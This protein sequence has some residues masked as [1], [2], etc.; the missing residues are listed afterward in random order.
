[1]SNF[2]PQEIEE[3]LQE[4]FDVVGARQ[5][6]GARYVPIFGRAGEATV[7]WDGLAPYEPLTVV[8]HEGISYVSRR[9]V[10]AGIQIANTD[11]WV[12]TYRFNAQV[13]QYRQEVLGF[14]GQIDEIREDFVP[15]PA[16]LELPKYGTL[17]Q[18]LTTLAN[19]ATKWEDP[20]VP[21][22][23]QAE[24]VIAA[25]LDEHP[26]ATTTVQDYS[27]T[28]V[29]I[30]DNQITDA[31]LAQNGN[32]LSR[33]STMGDTIQ[34]I[35][36]NYLDVDYLTPTGTDAYIPITNNVVDISN[37][38]EAP[39]YDYYI[40]PCKKDD[41]FILNGEGAV[42]ARFWIMAAANNQVL[43]VA[44]PNAGGNNIVLTIPANVAYLVINERTD[45][46]QLYGRSVDDRISEGDATN[47]A[48][49]E[50]MIDALSYSDD[51]VLLT[52]TGT[53]AYIPNSGSTVDVNSPQAATG[54][55]YY[56][57]DC[58]YM[59]EFVINGRGS[60]S[61]R[62]WSFIDADG[63]VL[64]VAGGDVTAD[65]LMI[66]APFTA[67][68]LVI[69]NRTEDMC[70]KVVQRTDAI[71][72]YTLDSSLRTTE[73]GTGVRLGS[74]LGANSWSTQTNR[75][76]LT[77][78]YPVKKGDI[79]RLNKGACAMNVW[80]MRGDGTTILESGWIRRDFTTN[81][82]LRAMDYVIKN[83][84]YMCANFVVYESNT[85]NASQVADITSRLSQYYGVITII[86]GVNKD[87]MFNAFLPPTKINRKPISI[88]DDMPIKQDGCFIGDNLWMFTDGTSTGVI[89]IYD[90][91]S[92]TTTT[93]THSLGHA[94]CVTYSPV[95][96][97][98]CLYGSNGDD[99][100]TIV[101]YQ[102]PE[103]ASDLQLTDAS[104]VV[105]PLY[106]NNSH[107]NV[108]ASVC[109]GEDEQTVY[110]IDGPEFD[111]SDLTGD[112]QTSVRRWPMSI[113]KIR[114]GMGTNDLSSGGFGTYTAV[115]DDEYNG[116]G[117]IVATYT[118]R[119]DNGI[120][121]DS[122]Y[123]WFVPQGVDFDGYIYLGYG[124]KNNTV[125]KILLDDDTLTYRA[126]DN[127]RYTRRNASYQ[128]QPFEPELVALH[129]SRVYYG[130]SQSTDTIFIVYER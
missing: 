40:V 41:V 129:G 127:Y 48:M 45:A 80:E 58:S 81:T 22:D 55:R 47:R 34:A 83:D 101:L 28:N 92:G 38:I 113:Y 27:I 60:I 46:K 126:I 44:E 99:K 66:I 8:M 75:L 32:V 105:I 33:V 50:Q 23:A 123:E 3:F 16:E 17:G 5:Y 19:G 112:W 13:E 20:V 102:N 43:S 114:L 121:Q 93:K 94:N 54:W 120:L 115:G 4:F 11:Y 53:D 12:Q 14:Q 67:T 96:D 124:V 18:V 56:V 25:W 90:I 125:V 122:P 15:F 52:P 84:C 111:A 98:L 30:A 78:L 1:M 57:C 49:S 26:E 24:S 65:G 69:N 10:P 72:A 76:S 87:P 70:W 88:R 106:D 109:F 7:E 61:A 31:K 71:D 6:V 51:A 59:D 29:K 79:V 64:S 85:Y 117:R 2:T 110:F 108:S 91:V 86:H 36:A 77:R 74:Y 130:G 68:R 103:N 128:I 63:N 62:L 95:S 116:T 37:P 100:P 107:M 104:C 82:M 35:S 97:A 118:G 39:N 89:N 73:V 119:I 21:S 9:Y 42:A